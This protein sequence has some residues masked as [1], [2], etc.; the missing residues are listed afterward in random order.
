[1]HI[2]DAG[3]VEPLAVP[4]VTAEDVALGE[5]ADQSAAGL[6][7]WQRADV[8]TDQER[9]R[10]AHGGVGSDV[11]D[12]APLGLQ[13]VAD[14]HPWSSPRLDAA[15]RGRGLRGSRGARASSDVTGRKDTTC[16][17]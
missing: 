5:D 10:L 2:A 17:S 3:A 6:D 16:L 9:D 11:D 13:D 7:D 1:H 4:V 14:L 8:V 15:R 12:P